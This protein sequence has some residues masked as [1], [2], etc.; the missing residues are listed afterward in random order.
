MER[1]VIIF[2]QNIICFSTDIL[3]SVNMTLCMIMYEIIQLIIIT[4]CQYE[5]I[6]LIIAVIWCE[7]VIWLSVCYSY[8]LR[9]VENHNRVVSAA[10]RRCHQL[11]HLQQTTAQDLQRRPSK[12]PGNGNCLLAIALWKLLS[13]PP[14]WAGA[15]VAG[16]K[17][18]SEKC[19]AGWFQNI[20]FCQCSFLLL[21]SSTLGS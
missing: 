3:L 6:G 7:S 2:C 13:A 17:H 16:L 5:R 11:Q 12:P 9:S 21:L 8:G 14:Q 1:V 18:W 20:V 10:P 19:L 4:P 15:L